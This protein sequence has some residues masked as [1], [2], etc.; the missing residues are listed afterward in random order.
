[1]CVCV[2]VGLYVYLHMQ[3]AMLCNSIRDN[4]C[5]FILVYRWI[6]TIN[7]TYTHIDH[8]K[9]VSHFSNFDFK[10]NFSFFFFFWFSVSIA[11]PSL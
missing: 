11:P 7:N 8:I 9:V 10:F 4:C 6:I 5:C 1:M 2:C 3:Y